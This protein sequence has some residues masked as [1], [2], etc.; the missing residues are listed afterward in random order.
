M[1]A[2]NGERNWLETYFE[3]T[4]L[5]AINAN[6]KPTGVVKS[7]AESQGSVELCTLA[8]E[9]TNEFEKLNKGREWD[10]EFFDEVEDFF[11]TKNLTA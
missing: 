7:V 10:G 3:L 11:R 1:K 8:I 5:I 6:Q 9:W 2:V 4:S